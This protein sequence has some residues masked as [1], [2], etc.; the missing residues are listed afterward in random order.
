MEKTRLGITVGLLGALIYFA[1][2]FS[3][4]L[5]TIILAGYVLM[6]EENPWLKR[7]AVKAVEL[8]VFFSCLSVI[9]NLIPD[10]VSFISNVLSVVNVN[11]GLIIISKIMSVINGG[12]D[13]V[14][15]VLFLGLGFKALRE[16]TIVIPALDRFVSKYMD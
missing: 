7:S 6:F 5:V 13:I 1:G 3:G 2:L 16:S 9:V 15:K 8:M 14:E 4:Y 12:I 10:A 11:F